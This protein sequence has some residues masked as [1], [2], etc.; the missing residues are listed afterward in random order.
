MKKYFV[1]QI[2]FQMKGK[3]FFVTEV[4]LIFLV[5]AN[6]LK[7]VILYS[8]KDVISMYSPF[9]IMLVSYNNIYDRADF[10]VLF[11]LLFP[12]L[13]VLP[14][15]FLYLN[16]Y[17]TGETELIRSR[18]GEN[19][20]IISKIIASFL[21]SSIAILIPMLLDLF[22]TSITFPC[23]A[24]G[25]LS[26]YGMYSAEYRYMS[27]NYLYGSLFDNYPILYVLLGMTR[28]SVFAGLTGSFCVAY[29]YSFPTKMRFL[30]FFPT[31]LIVNGTVFWELFIQGRLLNNSKSVNA[32]DYLL[33]FNEQEKSLLLWEIYLV[34]IIFMTFILV[35]H[36]KMRRRMIGDL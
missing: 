3:G 10:L 36:G 17:L 14:S 1:T 35:L 6:Y 13:A 16:E 5:L 24:I 27:G 25:D 23:Q 19:N 11:I 4:I 22:I 8:G 18:L 29:S 33:M 12:I 34:S 26:N 7:N 21:T 20:Y 9:K 30:Q 28:I 15:G 31:Y 2:V 32:Y